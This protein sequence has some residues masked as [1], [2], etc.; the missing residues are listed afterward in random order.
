MKAAR[1]SRNRVT[2]DLGWRLRVQAFCKV[3]ANY[4]SRSRKIAQNQS[5]DGT[6][7]DLPLPS[8]NQPVGCSTRSTLIGANSFPA[9]RSQALETH[10]ET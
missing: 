1:A 8:T 3:V 2:F 6:A 7:R 10:L 9:V 4:Y 5:V